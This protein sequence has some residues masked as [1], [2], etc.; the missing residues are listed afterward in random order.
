M[1][2]S[3]RAS[4]TSRMRE[5]YKDGCNLSA[6]MRLHRRF[7]VNKYGIFRWIFDHYSMPQSAR[8]LEIGSGTGQLWK[9]NADR[10]PAGWR[11]VLADFS[12]GILREGLIE[13]R[14]L[15]RRFDALAADAQ[16]QPFADRVFDAAVANFMLYHV[17]DI[18]RALRE[19][20]RVLR[21]GTRLY[22]ATMSTGNMREL[23]EIARR[24]IPRATIGAAPARFGLDN[25]FELLA[26]AFAN[27][28]LERY[29]DALVVTEA[30]PV[31]DY[32]ESMSTMAGRGSAEAKLAMR[33]YLEGEIAA[34]GSITI[35]K[36]NGLLVATV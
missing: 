15:D 33:Q 19:I 32:I 3:D 26:D 7:S 8:V 28:T 25:G 34:R 4:W 23:D 22:A 21:P 6:R 35:S 5:Q 2:Q 18:P 13:L 36:D 14:G 1:K 27:V 20:R 11:I 16:S 12:P 31:M 10:I 29:P 24:F 30:A 9:S 17:P